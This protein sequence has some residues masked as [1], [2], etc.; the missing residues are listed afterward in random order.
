MREKRFARDGHV[1]I[2]GN[3]GRKRGATGGEPL[4]MKMALDKIRIRKVDRWW[5]YYPVDHRAWSLEEILIVRALGRAVG[6]NQ[7]R[8]AAASGTPAALSVVGRGRGH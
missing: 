4:G 3:R 6:H 1:Q 8:L 7:C 5:D 2:F